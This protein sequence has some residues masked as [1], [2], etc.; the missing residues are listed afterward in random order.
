MDD[1]SSLLIF[2]DV[3]EQA[4]AFFSSAINFEPDTS[5][6]VD[7]EHLLRIVSKDPSGGAGIRN[8]PLI[9]RFILLIIILI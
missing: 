5:K 1:K 4:L 2:I 8:M 3:E 7:G 9:V 6:L